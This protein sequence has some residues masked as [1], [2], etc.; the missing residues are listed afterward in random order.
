MNIP[1]AIPKKLRIKWK[2]CLLTDGID[3]PNGSTERCTVI[4]A[5]SPGALNDPGGTLDAGAYPQHVQIVGWYDRQR[6]YEVWA[7]VDVFSTDNGPLEIFTYW[8]T[9]SSTRHITTNSKALLCNIPRIKFKKFKDQQFA[10]GV[11]VL[12]VFRRL[13]VRDIFPKYDTNEATLTSDIGAAPASTPFFHVGVVRTDGQFLENE[14]VRFRVTVGAS[15]ICY[16]RDEV[17]NPSS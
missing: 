2:K 1:S 14:A 17:V 15:S 3:T 7:A 6:T 16:R 12:R 13:K 8:T 10:A 5:V 9:D 4:A 11:R